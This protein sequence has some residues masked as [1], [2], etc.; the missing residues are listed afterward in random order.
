M[1][2]IQMEKIK[3][4]LSSM[5]ETYWQTLIQNNTAAHDTAARLMAAF[6]ENLTNL[7]VTQFNI[8]EAKYNGYRLLAE[9]KKKTAVAGIV[10]ENKA[11]IDAL[12][13]Q[14]RQFH[15]ALSGI[16]TE[17]AAV[18]EEIQTQGTNNGGNKAQ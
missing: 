10:K 16:L 13:E 9:N 15:T 14:K 3:R 7:S 12:T 5:D 6:T 11:S 1:A 8:T 17:L 18:V 2:E 4:V